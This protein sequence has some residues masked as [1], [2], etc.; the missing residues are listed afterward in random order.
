[1]PYMMQAAREIKHQTIRYYNINRKKIVKK[2]FKRKHLIKSDL[3]LQS[4][5]LQ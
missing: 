5:Q 4:K 2:Y 1:M 3:T